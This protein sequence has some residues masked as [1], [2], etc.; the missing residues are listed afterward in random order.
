T[1]LT[2]QRI[3]V[4]PP[5]GAQWPLGAGAAYE[6]R[7][8]RFLEAGNFQERKL[9]PASWSQSLARLPR[10][11][12]LLSVGPIVQTSPHA[13]QP[14]WVLPQPVFHYPG[15][16]AVAGQSGASTAYIDCSGAQY[17]SDWDMITAIADNMREGE[18]ADW[19]AQI[20][21]EGASPI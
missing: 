18:E 12:E 17:Q 6:W 2:E 20:H 9:Q 10:K 11:F 5:L 7:T 1:P 3:D 21:D 8:P 4:T 13:V 19:I 15:P 14:G 16:G